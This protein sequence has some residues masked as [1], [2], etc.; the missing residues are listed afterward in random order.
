MNRAVRM[1]KQII[2]WMVEFEEP[3]HTQPGLLE[4]L[5]EW[6]ESNASGTFALPGSWS[7]RVAFWNQDDAL[8]CYLTFK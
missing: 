4:N 8:L 2:A 7:H 5:T 1:R 3:M 6:C